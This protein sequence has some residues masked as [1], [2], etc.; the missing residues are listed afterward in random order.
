MRVS[1]CCAGDE[2]CYQ[3]LCTEC[4]PEGETP[5]SPDKCCSGV[6]EKGTCCGELG[7]SCEQR[8]LCRG[9]SYV[10]KAYARIASPKASPQ[11]MGTFVA[12]L[13]RKNGVCC[14]DP[15]DSCANSGCCANDFICRDGACIECLPEGEP[16]EDETKCCADS[17]SSGICCGGNLE[18]LYDERLLRG[19]TDLSQRIVQDVHRIRLLCG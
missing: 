7:F 19:R 5:D 2:L 14:G 13:T 16:T 1:D 8:M 10:I 11:L 9:D 17:A 12:A 4:L 18:Y 15:Y 3:G 6:A